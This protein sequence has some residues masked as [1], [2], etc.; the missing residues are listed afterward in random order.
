MKCGPLTCQCA[1]LDADSRSNASAR[2][3]FSSFSSL[4]RSLSGKSMR[5]AYMGS[6]LSRNGIVAQAPNPIQSPD[7]IVGITAVYRRWRAERV[8]GIVAIA[9]QPDRQRQHRAGRQQAAPQAHACQQVQRTE[10]LHREA[11]VVGVATIR[12]IHH[13]AP[14][15]VAVLLEAESQ[16]QQLVEL[17]AEQPTEVIAAEN[18]VLQN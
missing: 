14:R 10:H 13:G 6:L 12:R 15:D 8:S 5:L 7:R 3:E 17:A 16:V 11:Q 18:H 1:C 4:L 9:A 2:R